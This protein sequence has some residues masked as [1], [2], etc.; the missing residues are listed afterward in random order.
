MSIDEFDKQ[1]NIVVLDDDLK[2]EEAK[3]LAEVE[4]EIIQ[5]NDKMPKV[6]P[7]LA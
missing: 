2:A 7:L 1:N 4:A 5:D 3:R 6:K